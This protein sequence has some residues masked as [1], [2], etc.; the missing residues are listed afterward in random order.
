MNEKKGWGSTVV[1]WFVLQDEDTGESTPAESAEEGSASSWP[2]EQPM[3]VFGTE[4]PAAPGG[5]VDYEGVFA[6]A[7]INSDD[8]ARV[9]KAL[10][11][12]ASLPAETPF[13]VKKQI[14]EASLRAFEVPIDRI[15]ETGVQEIQALEAY[16]RAGASDTQKLIEES[17][18]R[19]RQ[20]EEEIV[21]IRAVMQDRVGE[22]QGVIRKCNQTKL[23]V[24]RILEF[25][26][27]DTVARVVRESPRLVDP[28]TD[29]ESS[30]E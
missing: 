7:G 8:Q 4:P 24:Q 15:I 3:N 20:F 9:T 1:G 18:N 5:I 14:V 16:I 17:E 30:D 25:F 27:Q 2:T 29:D 22:Q 23:D 19:I 10:E 26:G 13:D 6:A 11:L 12:V 21:R 28:P